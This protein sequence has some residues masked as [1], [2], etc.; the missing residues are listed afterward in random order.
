MTQTTNAAELRG[1]YLHTYGAFATS[2]TDVVENV[3]GVDNVRFARELLGTL[4][5][6]GLVAETE[7]GDGEVCWQTF[8]DSYDTMDQAEAESRIDNWLN[9][10]TEENTMSTATKTKPAAKPKEEGYHPCYCGCG[11]NVPA[12]S[13]YRPGH[14]ARHAGVIG[15]RVAETHDEEHFN[16]LPSDRLVIKAKGI[17]AKAIEKQL[18]KQEREA[19]KNAPE[20]VEGTLKVGKNERIGRKFKDGTVEYMDPKADEWKP[21]S[22]AAA[23]TFESE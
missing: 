5:Q 17:A 6:A 2:P 16:D 14:D 9:S 23:A 10:H 4:V 15:R 8:P 1:V 19:A 11:E 21:A 7:D 12:K 13:F 18:A 3:E 22:K 20:V